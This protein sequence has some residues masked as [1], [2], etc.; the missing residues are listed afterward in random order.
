MNEKMTR[1]SGDGVFKMAVQDQDGTANEGL[2]DRQITMA[3]GRSRALSVP[4]ARGRVGL[5]QVW[6][7]E[8]RTPQNWRVWG[9]YWRVDVRVREDGAD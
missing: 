7:R 3:S 9:W 8:D 1:G 5:R 4:E 6:E 2:F